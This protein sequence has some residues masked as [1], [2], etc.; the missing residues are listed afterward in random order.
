M[1]RM[2]ATYSMLSTCADCWMKGRLRFVDCLVP[3]ARDANLSFGSVIHECLKCWHEKRDPDAVQDIIDRAYPNR[4]GD[5]D[6]RHE[7]HLAGAMLRGYSARYPQEEFEVVVLEQPFEGLI[8]NPAT[9]RASLKFRLCGKVDGVV[10]VG[11]EYYLIEHK[12]TSQLDGAYIDKMWSDF[13]TTLYAGYVERC[14]GYKISGVYYNALLKARLQQSKGE[15][16]T[17]FETRRAD[18][19]AKSKTGKSSAQRRMPETDEE[20][21]ARLTE[22][23][24]DPAMFHREQL[25]ISRDRLRAVQAHVWEMTQLY[26]HIQRRGVWPQNPANCFR[27]GKACGYHPLCS[28][29]FSPTVRDNLYRIEPPHSEL[30]TTSTDDGQSVF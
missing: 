20:F 13:Q 26:L 12:T 17:E 24:S 14:L 27:Y 21:Q 25:I 29:D 30:H 10:R 23:Y 9:G 7:W 5:D 2:I 6:Q 18:L 16:E 28:S 8:I 1:N 3:Q 22:K 15:T 11:S 4:T 19:I